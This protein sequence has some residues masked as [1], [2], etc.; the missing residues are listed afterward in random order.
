M[1]DLSNY[2]QVAPVKTFVT[3]QTYQVQPADAV[4]QVAAAVPV[5]FNLPRIGGRGQVVMAECAVAGASFNVTGAGISLAA[6][7]YQIA[8]I[9]WNEL[10]QKWVSVQ[11]PNPAGLPA[12]ITMG[13]D[14]SGT[15][16][17]ATVIGLQGRP[18]ATTAPPTNYVLAWS[19]SAWA[20]AA[21]AAG[22]TGT[23]TQVNT[24]A[25]LTG[26]PITT[27][28]TVLIATAGVTNAMLANMAANTLK[29]NN[30]ASA[31]APIDL[32][33]AQTMT[34]LGAAPLASPTFTGTVTIPAGA[35]IAGFAPL[36]SPTFT[37]TPAA[38]TATAGTSTTQLATTA[39]VATSF[40][41]LASPALTGTPTAPTAAAAT[42]TTQVA[43]TAYVQSQGGQLPATAT[44]D[45]AAAG[46]LG[47]FASAQLL[48]A[49]AMSL[50]N[51]TA[52]NMLS[53]SL[54]AGDWEVYGNA[55]FNS[56]GTVSN[57]QANFTTTSAG[58]LDEAFRMVMPIAAGLNV[59]AA[60][61]PTQRF[62]L[63]ATTTV[64]AVVYGSFSTGTC[65][66]CGFMQARR[67]R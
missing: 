33:V 11:T 43:T 56:T 8:Q 45:N 63:A 34:L 49:S 19:G 22:G 27:T 18:V 31:A 46:K 14:I 16:A 67:M 15:A 42:N 58:L 13:G 41:P 61:I 21:P 44:N 17:A 51:G 28:G 60:P 57:V 32:T 37:G 4:L 62:S 55:V 50:T 20:P 47:E 54:T 3:A 64:Y 9:R 2:Q 10:T 7:N 1:P 53:L 30:T 36:A 29:G 35:S 65:T 66:A 39:F 52:A 12:S 59:V 5:T 6:N 24:G 48:L 38:P 25:G 26:G 23:V 40:A